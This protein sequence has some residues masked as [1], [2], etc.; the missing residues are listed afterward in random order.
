MYK[1]ICVSTCTKTKSIFSTKL[2]SNNNQSRAE[3]NSK[4]EDN[5]AV[6]AREAI[7]KIV[8]LKFMV[9][10]RL[11]EVHGDIEL[12]RVGSKNGV[13]IVEFNNQ[14]ES[15]GRCVCVCVCVCMCVCVHVCACVHVCV[16]V[17]VCAC[18]CG[19]LACVI[20]SYSR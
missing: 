16:K 7:N 17:C 9:K 15:V 13:G 10:W 5:F 19:V 3:G 12:D 18:V 4:E 8:Q 1:I 11:Q 2:T 20:Y 14:E 6:E